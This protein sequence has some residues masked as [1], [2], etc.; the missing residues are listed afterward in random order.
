M[1]VEW[2]L[3]IVVPIIKG[4]GDIRNCSC[5]GAVRHLEHGM[6][7]VERVLE[8]GLYRIVSVDERQFGFMSERGAIDAIFILRRMQEEY[9]AKIKKLYMC[10][11]DLEKAFDRV[12]WRVL[13]W[14]LWKKEI[15]EVL[16]RSVMSLYD[17]AKTMVRADCELS[18]EFEVNV[19]IHNGSVLSSFLFAVVVDVVTEFSRESA[20]S[21][22]LYADDLVLMSE[23]IEGIRNKFLKLI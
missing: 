9:H 2:A 3:S 8:K 14:A 23:T 17:G 4:K 12:P 22:L 5:Y 19:G 11:M 20:L 15:P 7:V 21:E 18:E 13:V 16:V 10:I 6:K 1:P